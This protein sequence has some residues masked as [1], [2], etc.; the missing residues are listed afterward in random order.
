M[1]ATSKLLAIALTATMQ[2]A[3]AGAVFLD[4]ENVTTT[5]RLTTQYAATKGVTVSGDAW[6]ATSEACTYGPNQNAGDVSFIRSG[7]CGALYIAKDPTDTLQLPLQSRSLT[8]TSANGFVDALSFV[9]S[10]SSRD[11]NLSVHAY[12]ANGKE[13]GAGITG[14]KG[15]AACGNFVFCSWPTQ[16]LSMSF[17]GVARTIVF[18][19]L[20]ETALLDDLSFTTAEPGNGQLPEPASV[21]L[22]LSALA[23][24]GWTRRRAAR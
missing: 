14:L 12:D 21:A 22:A 2:S 1:R 20:D 23:G 17:E 15:G 8:F 6:T 19:A 16:P 10:S 3:M 18:S 9:F 11:S 13:L 24:L 4:F 7:S 5:E